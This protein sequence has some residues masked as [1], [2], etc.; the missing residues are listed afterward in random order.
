VEGLGRKKH[1]EVDQGRSAQQ[2]GTLHSCLYFSNPSVFI[3]GASSSL[4]TSDT[5]F[6]WFCL[7]LISLLIP[8]HFPGVSTTNIV[9]TD[10][11]TMNLK[12]IS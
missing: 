8:H 11:D 1:C 7:G 6:P 10:M 3:M 9:S 5:G 4:H 2:D 12:S